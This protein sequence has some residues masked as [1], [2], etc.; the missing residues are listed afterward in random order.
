MAALPGNTGRINDVQ[1]GRV[2]RYLLAV[3]TGKFTAEQL[4]NMV[5]D[6]TGVKFSKYAVRECCKNYEM[7]R[8]KATYNLPQANQ[9]MSEHLSKLEEHLSKLEDR[10]HDLE[11]VMKGLGA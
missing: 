7:A 8:P 5:F 10:V 6:N 9:K 1:R 4:S 2:V 3:E 11:Q